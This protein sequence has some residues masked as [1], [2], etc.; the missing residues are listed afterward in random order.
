MI[1]HMLV[2]VPIMLA[3]MFIAGI[4]VGIYIANVIRDDK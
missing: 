2:A 1:A 4:L 3:I